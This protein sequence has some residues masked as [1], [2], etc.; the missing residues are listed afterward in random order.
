MSETT[1][2]VQPAPT[3]APVD[4]S[5]A[6]VSQ[7][8]ASEKAGTQDLEGEFARWEIEPSEITLSKE[9]GKGAFGV[10]YKGT[11]RGKSVAVK[12]L[13]AQN[14]DEETLA[15]FRKEVAIMSK[16]RHPNVL[17]FMGAC[18]AP[19]NLMIV[20][21]L[22]PRGS[23][24][25]LL[26]CE[27]ELDFTR[28]MKMAHE[29]A[30][31]MNWLHCSKPVFIHRDLKTGNLL[32]DDNWNVKVS[33]FGLS[34]IK[35]HQE[36]V[37]GSYGAIGTP[38]WMAPEVLLNK[39]YDEKADLYSFGIVLWELLTAQD[40]FPNIET[41]SMM[42]D[43]VCID[44]ERPEIPENCPETLRELM[45]ACW[46]PEPQRRP[47]FESLL[48]NRVFDKII[49]EATIKDKMGRALWARNFMGKDGLKETVTWREFA[50][51]FCNFFKTP[52]PKDPDDIKFKCLKTILAEKDDMVTMDNFSRHLEWFG[53]MTGIDILDRV[54]SLL[55]KPWFHGEI[56]TE[57]AEK[58]LT[59]KGKK[60]LFLVRF[61]SRDPGCYAITVLSQ[62]GKLKHFRIY[63]RP[64]LDFLI[65]KTECK[66]LDDIIS[67]YHKELYLKTPCPGSPYEELFKSKAKKPLSAGYQTPD[68]D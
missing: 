21:E 14:L 3:P 19:G 47:S 17:L 31:G 61:S 8:T 59:N 55:R 68:F 66:S 11:L 65:G 40:P 15:S 26:H 32:V 30:L 51:A 7:S 44:H 53:P 41:F 33:D 67:K 2:S 4:G 38:L 20:T 64:G 34:H 22:M 12:K 18:T 13:N 50:T 45:E 57:D 29:A 25:D 49:L 43:Q 27:T 5:R 9:L 16:L 56:S 46:D 42:L 60:G 36:G 48:K 28:K 35:Q 23:V 39:D 1:K 10:V 62:G 52:L 58:L 6:P 24:Y 54:E 37:R 63:H